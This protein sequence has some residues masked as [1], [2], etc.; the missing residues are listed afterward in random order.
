[1]LRRRIFP[2][3]VIK[4]LPAYTFKILHIVPSVR[5]VKSRELRVAEFKCHIAA[6]GNLLSILNGL[7]KS[8]KNFPHLLLGFYIE[9]VR[10]KSHFIFFATTWF[11]P[12]HTR[13][14]CIFASSLFI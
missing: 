1:M 10:F 5:R 2:V 13:T 9:F 6:V 12:I 3:T 7:R 4:P 11:V 14:F 8:R